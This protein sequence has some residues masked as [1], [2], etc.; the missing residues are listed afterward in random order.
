MG[1]FSYVNNDSQRWIKILSSHTIERLKK[2]N[3]EKEIILIGKNNVAHPNL[4]NLLVKDLVER[5][6]GLIDLSAA[7]SF[8]VKKVGHHNPTNEFKTIFA[9]QK[10]YIKRHVIKLIDNVQSSASYRKSMLE[11]LNA[12]SFNTAEE[13]DLQIKLLKKKVPIISHIKKENVEDDTT[14]DLKKKSKFNH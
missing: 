7:V 3:I 2:I 12:L 14:I 10:E 13:C 8:I 5:I 4:K 1:L 9:D 6:L 11:A